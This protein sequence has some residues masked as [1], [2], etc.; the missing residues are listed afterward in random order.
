M[1]EPDYSWW[2]RRLSSEPGVLSVDLLRRV[3]ENAFA[4]SDRLECRVVDALSARCLLG[5]S[6]GESA[7]GECF[8]CRV[9]AAVLSL[10]ESEEE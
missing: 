3:Y 1:S 4:E 7:C 9:G 8:E 2:R 6:R 5:Q 10:F